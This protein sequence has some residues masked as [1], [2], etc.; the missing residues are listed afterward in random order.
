MNRGAA[1]AGIDT[2]RGEL[3]ALGHRTAAL[4]LSEERWALAILGNQDG[5]W[6]W[7]SQ[8]GQVFFSDRWKSMLGYEA[9]EI[10]NQIDEW[11]TRVHPQDLDDV[12]QQ[13]RRHLQG[14]AAVYECEHRMRH[15]DGRYLWMLAR[16]Q[17]Q[18]DAAGAEQ[19]MTGSLNDVTDR[20]L[21][22][23]ALRDQTEELNTILNLSPD[24][25]VS[26]DRA[27]HVKYLSPAFSQMTGRTI[28]EL[29]G[30]DEAAFWAALAGKQEET[31][32]RSGPPRRLLELT[33]PTRRVLDISQRLSQAATVSQILCFRDVTHEAE[34]DRFKTEFLSTAAHELRTPLAS[35]YGFAELLL[36]QA[37]DE[38]SRS[39]FIN[40]I[41]TQSQQMS[42][43]LNELLDLV[44]I[45]ARGGKD[46]SLVRIDA[47]T[48]VQQ[49]ASSLRL[50][51]GRAMPTIETN[52][53]A[54]FLR[55]D[56]GKTQQAIANVLSNAYKYSP[57][58]G[59]VKVRI[60]ARQ[61]A[62]DKPMI[63]ICISDPGIGMQPEQTNRIFE[64]F[65]RADKSG[66]IPGTGLGMSIVKELIELQHGSVSVQS[67]PGKGTSVCL[68]LP[69]DTEPHA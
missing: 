50:P 41:F 51:P 52:T 11:L 68:L 33:E 66:K 22:Q 6:D 21:A 47:R 15:K 63:G 29:Q 62:G 10:G 26:F 40:V 45:E 14:E 44:R 36:T 16:G 3:Q 31:T 23:E 18:W 69:A 42:S 59:V 5:I 49:V 46:M 34:V 28:A 13:L 53:S 64:R 9:A 17:A 8:S 61:G 37:L 32:P 1:P 54:P 56:P 60:E 57:D 27:G 12:M 4:A 35:I 30:L 48:L 55:V 67:V 2:L 65:Y 38:A 24:G 19:R 20:R 39:E 25:F 58:G 7:D 43:L